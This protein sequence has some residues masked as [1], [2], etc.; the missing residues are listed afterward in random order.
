MAN[1]M[2]SYLHKNI[3]KVSNPPGGASSIKLGWDE[4]PRDLIHKNHS[5]IN[6][7]KSLINHNKSLNYDNQR[8]PEASM[9]YPLQPKNSM[10][11]S[12]IYPPPDYNQS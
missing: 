5:S 11:R 8:N 3:F 6:H 9:L 12:N 4:P 10:N 7:N 1:Y 2:D